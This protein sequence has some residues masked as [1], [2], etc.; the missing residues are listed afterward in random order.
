MRVDEV[1]S[2]ICLAL[3]GGYQRVYSGGRGARRVFV[4]ATNPDRGDVTK[5]SLNLH[6]RQ[7]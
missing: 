7:R 4:A 3:G 2:R 1:A 5:W 6:Q